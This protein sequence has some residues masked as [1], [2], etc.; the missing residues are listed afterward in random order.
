MCLGMKENNTSS[1]ARVR[2]AAQ[3][4]LPSQDKTGRPA[5]FVCTVIRLSPHTALSSQLQI[6]D[7]HWSVCW[8]CSSCSISDNQNHSEHSLT[9]RRLAHQPTTVSYSINIQQI[10]TVMT[11]LMTAT[12]SVS[13]THQIF[14]NFSRLISYQ[15]IDERE[16][17]KA[18]TTTTTVT[19]YK[20]RY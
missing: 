5:A 20:R 1:S 4:V 16:R 3:R 7:F 14:V 8:C 13:I 11:K 9:A 15:N 19:N 17:Q 6:T 18:T 2:G 12:V 10:I